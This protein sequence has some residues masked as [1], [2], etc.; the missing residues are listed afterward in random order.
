MTQCDWNN[1]WMNEWVQL[2]INSDLKT[3]RKTVTSPCDSLVSSRYSDEQTATMYPNN[4]RYY[5]IHIHSACYT[6]TYCRIVTVT[7]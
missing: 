6:H 3:E 4:Y 1:E 7:P 5:T 2:S